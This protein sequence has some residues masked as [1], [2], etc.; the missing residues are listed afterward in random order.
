[1]HQRAE[2]SGMPM[3]S[4][5]GNAMDFLIVTEFKVSL[6]TLH[7]SW[8]LSKQLLNMNKEEAN[9]SSDFVLFKN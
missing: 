2:F 5:W 6:L 8:E 7:L 3:R 9:L 4:S 1:M